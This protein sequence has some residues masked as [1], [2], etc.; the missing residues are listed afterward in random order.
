M[1]KQFIVVHDDKYFGTV[2][3]LVISLED[4]SESGL[5]EDEKQIISDLPL[6][7]VFISKPLEEVMVF[8]TFDI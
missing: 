5:K 2:E 6:G 8:R 3:P 1:T 4:L 7:G